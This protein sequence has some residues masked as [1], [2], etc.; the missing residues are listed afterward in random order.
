MPVYGGIEG[1]WSTFGFT[2]VYSA[3]SAQLVAQQGGEMLSAVE[4]QCREAQPM[5]CDQH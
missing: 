1:I 2:V 5:L 4:V 3:C